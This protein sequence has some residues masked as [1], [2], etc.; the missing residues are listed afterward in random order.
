[1]R[2]GFVSATLAAACF[3]FPQGL[4]AQSVI[5]PVSGDF[6]ASSDH[7]AIAPDGAPIITRYD[8]GFYLTSAAQPFQVQ[9]LGKPAPAGNGRISFP[10]S[11]MPLPSPGI[12]YVSRVSAVGPGGA[13]TSA[14]SNTFMFSAPCT[15]S[16]TLSS[17]T[18][19]ASGG[20]ANLTVTTLPGCVWSVVSSAGWLSV[21]SAANGTGSGSVTL[22]AAPNTS[23]GDRSATVTVAGQAVTV[24][25]PQANQLTAP[26]GVHIVR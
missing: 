25:Q 7:N 21:S 13:G 16:L 22:S 3:L 6:A 8:L 26:V 19:P 10:L 2:R 15:F 17:S 9:S 14:P 12:I 1:M 18:V 11:G 20:G 23:G 4:S 24:T 5:N